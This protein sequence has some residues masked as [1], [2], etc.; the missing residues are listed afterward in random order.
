MSK[1]FDI[2]IAGSGIYGTILGTILAKNGLR[3]KIIELGKH[4]RF[5]LGEAMLPQS[6]LWPFIIGEY[7]QIPEIQ[8]LSH[9]DRII[10][11]ITKTC[12]IKHSIGFAYHQENQKI[13]SKKIHQLIPPH[14][15]FYSEGHLLRE[16]IDHYLL[17]TAINYGCEYA[18]ETQIIDVN[19]DDATV[20]I[21]TNKET[22]TSSYFIDS[23]GK[24]S[25]LAIKE[26]LRIQNEDL[27]TDSRC[28]FT[29]VE[30]LKPFDQQ[31]NA[32]E[33]PN[34]TKKLHHGT[35]H[36]VFN[37][38][39]M[40]VI[41]FDNHEKSQSKLSSVGIVLDRNVHPENTSLSP[42]E[43]FFSFVETFPSVKEHFKNIKPIREFI[44]TQR[45]Q[46]S[47]RQSVGN[48]Y[49]L[50][51]NTFGFIDPLYSNGLVHCFESIFSAA[52]LLLKASN[53]EGGLSNKSNTDATNFESINT[54][55]L[56]QIA[57]A[58]E[59]V[60]NAYKATA[61]FE[62]WN[63]WTQFWLAQVLF[64]DLWIQRACFKYFETGKTNS[65]EHF[66]AESRPG[67]NAPFITDKNKLLKEITILLTK[68]NNKQITSEN[69]AT[70][71]LKLLE[72]QSWLPM[73]SYQWGNVNSRH[74]DFSKMENA[75]KL[76][77]WGFTKAP[78]HLKNQLFDFKLP[79]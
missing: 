13:E 1:K 9:A 22:I 77:G 57:Q 43:E 24:N 10:E 4:P 51:N 65:F 69:S 3:V 30:G 33:H 56:E 41:P 31:L 54:L 25:L 48:R 14:M 75:Q 70:E 37:G 35:L 2:V 73:D 34:Q 6:A 18:E 49:M 17:K 46:Y 47:A 67:A 32:I 52:N 44:R 20:T 45:L 29:H 79:G 64:H 12:G 63:A 61:S 36:H 59:M 68:F 66:L 7:F 5:A 53:K 8:H 40:W 71:I 28:I 23:S 78:E 50:A 26:D 58:D 62:T 42:E 76:L 60:S 15:P 39:W 72:K 74:V 55:H 27:M 21:E 19:I 16:D 11:N 38:G